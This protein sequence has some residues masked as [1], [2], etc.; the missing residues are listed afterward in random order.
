MI[1][2]FFYWKYSI[3]LTEPNAVIWIQITNK[4]PRPITMNVTV[5]FPTHMLCLGNHLISAY[6]GCVEYTS[7]CFCQHL[8]I[9]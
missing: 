2:V 6:I 4:H 9:I 5:F 7:S 1:Y 3:N 8:V